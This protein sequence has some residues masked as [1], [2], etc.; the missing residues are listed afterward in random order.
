LGAQEKKERGFY[1]RYGAAL[2]PV[3]VA[4]V[5]SI[6]GIVVA[7][8]YQSKTSATQLISEREKAE[9]DLRASMFRDLIS[10]ILGDARGDKIPIER[11]RLLVELLA[12]NF[13]DHFELKPLLSQTD[14]TIKEAMESAE[15]DNRREWLRRERDRLRSVARRVSDRQIAILLNQGTKDDRTTIIPL[16]LVERRQAIDAVQAQVEERLRKVKKEVRGVRDYPV[17]LC[18]PDRK[19]TVLLTYLDFDWVN[20]TCTTQLNV[21]EK[22]CR[23]DQEDFLQSLPAASSQQAAPAMDM[24]FEL[25]WFD[26]PFTDNTLLSDGNRFALVIQGVDEELH[27]ADFDLIWFPKVY[28]SPRERPINYA[29]IRRK[30][31]MEPNR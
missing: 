15:S 8:T 5:L 16:T 24:K 4:A 7:N 25:S 23:P 30:L 14:R 9:S 26:F 22:E 17:V 20:Q 1:E 12:L 18:S 29:E 3:L 6:V 13:G 28:F 10:P 19:Y 21:L 11:Q 31:D 27:Y 2:A